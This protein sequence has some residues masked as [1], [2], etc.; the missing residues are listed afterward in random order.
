MH[1]LSFALLVLLATPSIPKSN[2]IKHKDQTKIKKNLAPKKQVKGKSLLQKKKKSDK[3]VF[4]TKKPLLRVLSSKKSSHSVLEKTKKGKKEKQKF[5]LMRDHSVDVSLLPNKLLLWCQHRSYWKTVRLKIFIAG[6]SAFDP[7]ELYG[8]ARFLVYLLDQA[9]N[10]PDNPA[11]SF[12]PSGANHYK[13]SLHKERIEIDVDLLPKQLGG[14]LAHI[15]SMLKKVPKDSI[16]TSVRNFLIRS[17]GRYP[18]PSITEMIDARLFDGLARGVFFQ[19]KKKTFSVLQ[20]FAIQTAYSALFKAGNIRIL[21][22]SALPCKVVKNEINKSFLSLSN[23]GIKSILLRRKNYYS[24]RNKNASSTSR[25]SRFFFARQMLLL[26]QLPELKR[27]D[28]ISLL[29]VRYVAKQELKRA[30]SRRFGEMFTVQSRMKLYFERGYLSFIFPKYSKKQQELKA[31]SE[32]AI[33]HLLMEP[34]PPGIESR[35]KLYRD[36][37]LLKLLREE[38]SMSARMQQLSSQ[39]LL[40]A[41]FNYPMM[42]KPVL[43]G[44]TTLSFRKMARHFLVRSSVFAHHTQPSSFRNI[45]MLLISILLLWF[46]L[47][48][49][50]RRSRREEE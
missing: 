39:M 2:Q 13:V 34:Y 32:S 22:M 6:G 17:V 3:K 29:F 45:T 43:A 33:G 12:K 11:H 49:L 18:P 21:I 50:I 42:A 27:Q 41:T 25:E 4:K 1:F 5:S 14:A 9:L 44:V 47:D 36:S 40:S 23:Q 8:Q 46:F 7:P 15:V 35:L 30:L 48:L 16:N 19:G 20:P 38:S 26:Y 24:A 28:Y 10:E 31:L 37:F